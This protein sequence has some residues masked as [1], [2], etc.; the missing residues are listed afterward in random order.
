M[1]ISQ[2]TA[3]QAYQLRKGGTPARM[4]ILRMIAADSVNNRNESTRLAPGDWRK[5]RSWGLH[6]YASAYSYGMQRGEVNGRAVWFSFGGTA[7]RNERDAHN[8]VRLR[9]TGWFTDSHQDD[10]AVGIVG[11]LS[12]G[13]FVAGYRLT[14]ND[15]RVYF[16]EVFT[17]EDDAA[18]MADEHARIIAEQERE[19]AEKHEEARRLSDE[20]DDACTEVRNAREE[21]TMLAYALRQSS[22]VPRY[23]DK[24]KRRMQVLRESVADAV[25]RIRTNRDKLA[26]DYRDCL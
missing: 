1:T 21:H 20:V 5:A 3:I 8:I 23:A 15:E 11:S 4:A 9:H 19:H 18:R 2:H 17:D 13:R 12:H 16:D 7:V 10:M 25:E 6:S 14:M 26:S 24:C 22:N